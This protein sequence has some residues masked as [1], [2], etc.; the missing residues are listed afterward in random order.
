MEKIN[1]ILKMF[2][3]STDILKIEK[4][5]SGHINRTYKIIYS[6]QENYI[7]QRI[8]GNVFTKPEEIMSNIE[9]ICNCLKGKVCCPEFIKHKNKNYIISN[10]E[11]W[12]TYKY[13]ENSVSYNALE[14]IDKI[15]EFGRITGE[16]HKLTENLNTDN[17]YGVI[18]NFHNTSFILKNLIKLRQEAYGSEFN[19]FEKSLQYSKSLDKKHLPLRVTHNDVKCSNVLFD[20]KSGKGITLIDFD[21]V[22]PGLTVYDFGDGARSACVTDNK[23]NIEKFEAYCSGY[24]SFV[25]FGK[26]EDYFLALYNITAEL[27]ARYFH[28]FLVSGNYFSDKTPEQK[29]ERSRQLITLAESILENKKEIYQTILKTQILN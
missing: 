13:I 18:N 2:G 19:F 12:R 25:N 8:N 3:L 9:G 24:F 1:E 27:S 15:Y 7:L 17:F 14:D 5:N 22:M 21:T 23:F 29:L 11:M 28:D 6:P 20:I 4:I 26:A 16:F 10:N